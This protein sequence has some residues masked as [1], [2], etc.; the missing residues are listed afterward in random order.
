MAVD[1]GKWKSFGNERIITRDYNKGCPNE[2][3]GSSK[4]QTKLEE[5]DTRPCADL[6]LKLDLRKKKGKERASIHEPYCFKIQKQVACAIPLHNNHIGK[7]A[8]EKN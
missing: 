4:T 5:V 6:Q 7:Q 8:H 2:D 1:E 3:T